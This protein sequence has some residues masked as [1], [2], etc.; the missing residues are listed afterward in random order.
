MILY[1]VTVNIEDSV[2][3]EWLEWMTTKHI[4]DVLATGLFEGNKIY[5]IEEPEAEE[6]KSYSIQYFCRSMDEYS[7]YKNEFAP[8]LQA[9]HEK[10]YAGKFFAFRSILKEI[11]RAE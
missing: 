7:K 6:G 2:H 11:E 8:A 10:K 1:N 5:R 4:P 3:D 9:E